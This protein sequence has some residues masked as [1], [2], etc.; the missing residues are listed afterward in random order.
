MSRHARDPE[1]DPL[2]LHVGSALVP[3][4]GWVGSVM[5]G[6]RHRA[7]EPSGRHRACRCTSQEEHAGRGAAGLGCA[8]PIAWAWELSS[9]TWPLRQRILEKNGVVI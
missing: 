8:Y 9:R 5:P 2:G 6:G 4:M 3:S 7:E 1:L